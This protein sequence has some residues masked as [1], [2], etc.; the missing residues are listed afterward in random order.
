MLMRAGA[1]CCSGRWRIL[2][3]QQSSVPVTSASKR[4]LNLERLV[5]M[6]LMKWANGVSWASGGDSLRSLCLH[7]AA[8][9]TVGIA[10]L[11]DAAWRHMRTAAILL[12]YENTVAATSCDTHRCR[13]PRRS[14]AH[15]ERL[16]Y[17]KKWPRITLWTR[18]R[19]VGDGA[20][21]GHIK[22]CG[23]RERAR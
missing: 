7:C 5:T 22:R 14:R 16:S 19:C 20:R 9:P 17:R 13:T 11:A 12:P 4:A 18:L 2:L 8:I 3:R 15:G 21:G 10:P 23:S 6:G 1:V